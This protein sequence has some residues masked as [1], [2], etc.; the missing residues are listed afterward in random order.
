MSV[1]RLRLV[2]AHVCVAQ[3][4]IG[5]V[6]FLCKPLFLEKSLISRNKSCYQPVIDVAITKCCLNVV[7]Q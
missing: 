7:V 1:R 5:A 4:P 6:A 2:F 3:L